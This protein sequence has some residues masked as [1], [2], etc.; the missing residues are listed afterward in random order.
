MVLVQKGGE[1]QN[2]FALFRRTDVWPIVDV[3]YDIFFFARVCIIHEWYTRWVKK[4]QYH[5]RPVA[6]TIIFIGDAYL[7]AC[8]FF[9]IK[10]LVCIFVLPF[11]V[12]MALF[13]CEF[14]VSN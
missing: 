9:Y 8:L 7:D 6:N 10:K 14:V 1:K 5:R 13:Y 4:K 12:K 3:A 2:I 11:V